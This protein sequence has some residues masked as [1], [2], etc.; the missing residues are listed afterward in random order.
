MKK[1][2][3]LILAAGM[4]SRYGGLKQLDSFGPNGETIIDYSIYDAIFAGFEKI[5]FIIRKS[6]EQEFRA[7]ME[8]RWRNKIEMDYVYQELTDL[9]E[10]YICPE[11]R[12]KPWGT[13]HALWSARDAIREP[14]GVINADDY[15]GR[16]A[17]QVLYHFLLENQGKKDFAVVA[18]ELKNTLSEHGAVNRGVCKADN[19][20][21][22]IQVEEWRGIARNEKGQICA[23]SEN[24]FQFFEENTLVSMNMWAFQDSYFAWAEDYFKIFLSRRIEESGSEFYIPELIQDLI[25]RNELTVSILSSPSHWFGVTYKEDK[26]FVQA[27]FEKMI[28]SNFYPK[29]L[30]N[31]SMG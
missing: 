11:E 25:E 1:P 17:I 23:K 31:E 24:G 27:E 5:V 21:Q 20:G 7:R 10:G 2:S 4:G 19:A 29:N 9:P 15:Y 16:E 22:L 30:T 26:P 3:L 6:F 28:Q 18:Y 14:F 8:E 13:G 12:E